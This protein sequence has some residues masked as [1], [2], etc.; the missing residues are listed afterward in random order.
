MLTFAL[1]TF[2]KVFMGVQ[3]AT[4]RPSS[5]LSTLVSSM[6]GLSCDITGLPHLLPTMPSCSAQCWRALM[7]GSSCL[8]LPGPTFSDLLLV[9]LK[10]PQT[11][12]T[13]FPKAC[14]QFL[15]IYLPMILQSF[16]VMQ[17]CLSSSRGSITAFLPLNG[18]KECFQTLLHLCDETGYRRRIATQFYFAFFYWF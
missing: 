10:P 2:W 4:Q 1:L 5:T 14:L 18:G 6:K 9:V 11:L 15:F 12:P 16:M 7:G 17:T 13:E 3:R 8:T